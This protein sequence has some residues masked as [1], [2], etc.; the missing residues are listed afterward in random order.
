MEIYMFI[1][2]LLAMSRVWLT[3]P[4]TLTRVTLTRATLYPCPITCKTAKWYIKWRILTWWPWP[5]TYDLDLQGR[6]RGCPHLYSDQ[7]WRPYVQYFPRYEL[8][9]S[10]FLSSHRRTDA[11][12]CIRAHRALAQVG[13]IMTC[14][15][16]WLFGI[17]NCAQYYTSEYTNSNMFQMN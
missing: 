15:S 2:H 3:W 11:K 10:D 1:Q 13:S 6:P 7:I 4:L 8:L 5:L 12:W 17:I 9:S 16:K 14:R